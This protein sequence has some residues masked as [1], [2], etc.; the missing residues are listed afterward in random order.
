MGTCCWG[1]WRLRWT[2]GACCGWPPACPPS[3]SAPTTRATPTGLRQARLSTVTPAPH[4]TV[5]GCNDDLVLSHT[6]R[7]TPILSHVPHHFVQSLVRN[8]Y[9]CF[10]ASQLG[11]NYLHTFSSACQRLPSCG[12]CY[13]GCTAV[14]SAVARV[15]ICQVLW[16]LEL[17]LYRY[18]AGAWGAGDRYLLKLFRDYVFHQVSC[19]QCS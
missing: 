2:M 13:Y 19:R 15:A 7:L 6:R 4:Q 1:S 12:P 11:A 17:Y 9:A 18:G 10:G 3:P 14:A 5:A 16:M 8:R